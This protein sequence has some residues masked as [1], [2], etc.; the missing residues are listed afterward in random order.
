[1]Q[2]SDPSNALPVNDA[3]DILPVSEGQVFLSRASQY[4]KRIIGKSTTLAEFLRVFDRRRGLSRQE[5]LQI[6]TLALTLLEMNY[7]NLPLKRALHAVDPIQRLKLL[8]FR[9]AEM[10]EGD[11]PSERL[12]H[13]RMLE[14]FTSARDIHTMYF[15]PAPFTEMSAYLPFLIEEYFEKKRQ[16]FM[17]SRLVELYYRPRRA[18][19]EAFRHFEP[20]VEALYW[21]GIPIERAIEINGEKQAGSNVEARFARGLDNLT[22][23][24]LDTSLPPDEHWVRLTYRAL[25]GEKYELEQPWLVFNP[26]AVAAKKTPASA[27]RERIE[28]YK[29]A[30][31]Q[32]V[33][34]K[35]KEING[36][37]KLLYTDAHALVDEGL[38]REEIRTPIP[39]VLRAERIRLHGREFGYLR[40]FTFAV[41]QGRFVN[42]VVRILTS[43]TFP[44]DGLILDVRGNGGGQ[45]D[46]AERLLQLFTPRR[47]KPELFEFINTPLN[48]EICRS[49]PKVWGMGRWAKSIAESVMTSATYS[50]GFPITSEE[51]CNDIGQVYY[52]P[53]V[54]ITDALS[55]SAT[56]IFAA[57]FQD[58]GIG[59]ILG[60]SGNT[61]AGGA[62]VWPL[63]AFIIALE[64]K[65]G[66]P[67]A[68]LPKG[69][70]MQ[71]A[72]RRSIRV[73]KQAGQPL[74][75]LGVTPD[76]RHY[77]TRNDLLKRNSELL[78]AAAGMLAEKPVYGLSVTLQEHPDQSHSVTVTTRNLARL[79]LYINDRPYRSLDVK[80]GRRRAGTISRNGRE[81]ETVL[82]LNGY[83]QADTLVA[84]CKRL[85]KA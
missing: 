78:R 84:M 11:L 54:L 79:D 50:S 25:N 22:I 28:I 41:S 80:D 36:V 23:R 24:P 35:K 13:Q 10:K 8:K 66:S 34:H 29:T 52:G 57:G 81:G 55:Y 58:N 51:A 16:K 4:R 1:M 7:V 9:L 14:I 73:G 69:V 44:R 72:V 32:A 2:E 3:D 30:H 56:D 82:L 39:D 45:I 38:H 63:E 49:A 31:K 64:K 76:R 26:K 46:A 27:S 59:E 48:L 37:K 77:M 74:E 12:F 6:V 65:A 62:N 71:A 5:R 67:F 68:S 42:S 33:D 43:E 53:V 47:I 21:N 60:T 18:Q 19:G 15:L 40:I 83:D 85:I 17:V 70:R 75:E 20:G 61:G